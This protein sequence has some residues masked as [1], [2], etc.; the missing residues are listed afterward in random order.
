[1][2]PI[3]TDGLAVFAVSLLLGGFAFYCAARYVTY[4][5]GDGGTDFQHAV[6]TALFGAVAWAVL[7]VVPVVGTAAALVG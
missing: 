2:A 6:V 1:M 5:D 7:A 4:R 3:L